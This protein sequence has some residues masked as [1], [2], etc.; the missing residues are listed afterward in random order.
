VLSEIFSWYAVDF[1]PSPIEWIA[2]RRSDLELTR[3][4][5][6]RYRSYDWA[7]NRQ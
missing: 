3:D 2:K 6:V 4:T 7:L 1:E 5:P